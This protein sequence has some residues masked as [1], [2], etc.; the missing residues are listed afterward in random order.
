MA[1]LSLRRFPDELQR[2]LKVEAAKRGTTLQ[3]LVIQIAADWL[4][5]EGAVSKPAKKKATG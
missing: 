5:R 3:A 4:A 1:V 2:A